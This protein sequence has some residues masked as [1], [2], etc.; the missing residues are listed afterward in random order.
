MP[1]DITGPDQT[2]VAT[3]NYLRPTAEKPVRWNIEP[4]PGTPV[5][6]GVEDP[7]E[8]AIHDA[9]PF[10]DSFTLDTSGFAFATAPTRVADFTDAGV[11]RAQY[12]PEVENLLR[13]HLG[14]ARVVVFDHNVRNAQRAGG[15]QAEY[16]PPVRRVHNDY[17]YVSSP[18]RVRDLLGA[19]AEGLLRHRFAVVN[20]W[21]P[22]RGP[23]LDAPLALCDARS[24]SDDDLVPTGLVHAD[25]VGET[26]S[27]VHRP[28]HLWYYLS[29]M[30]S[31]E[32]VLIKGYDSATDGRARLSFHSAFDNPLA[33]PDA[34][35]R[36][37]IEVRALVF[38][39]PHAG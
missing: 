19:E 9:R 25:R 37:S 34:P 31:D 35:P 6:N 17:T 39:P 38:F 4:P 30:Q 23:V 16:R 14:A 12:Y 27:V 26:Y 1:L 5:W 36:E 29:G 24:F 10:S 3:L 33:P 22:L 18:Q 8:V 28:A 11:I 13:Q 2:V 15:G 7:H 21:R 32:V 20:V